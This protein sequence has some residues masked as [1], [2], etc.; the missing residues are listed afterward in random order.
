MSR[1]VSCLPSADTAFTCA[2]SAAL[3]GIDGDADAEHIAVIL[4][5]LLRPAY[6][7]VEVHRQEPLAQMFDDE[8]WYAY[9]DGKP[10]ADRGPRSHQRRAQ[11]LGRAR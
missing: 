7:T 3:D 1:R 8:V 6:P 9:R 11:A 5:D 10:V 2:A 4:T